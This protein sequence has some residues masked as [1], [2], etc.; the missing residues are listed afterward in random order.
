MVRKQKTVARGLPYDAEL[1]NRLEAAAKKGGFSC[2][3]AFI[4][5]AIERELARLSPV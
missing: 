1:N 4:R 5:A 3:S 2:G